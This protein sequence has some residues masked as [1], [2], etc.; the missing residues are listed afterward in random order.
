MTPATIK[1][2]KKRVAGKPSKP[3]PDFPL[4]PHASGR[5]AK[6]IRQQFCYFGKVA[7]DPRGVAALAIWL[8][9]KDELLAG[10]KP[11]GAREGLTIKGLVNEFLNAKRHLL[12]TRE[13]SARMFADWYAACEA[14]TAEYGT[15]RFVDD[16]LPADFDGLRR[17]LE[18]RYGPHRL[19]STV[20]RVRG[21]FKF[22][23]E[24]R[25]IDRPTHFGTGF[26][27]PSKKTMR[28]HRAKSG[29]KMFEA[30]ELRKIIDGAGVPL[31]AMILLGA[32]CGFGNSDIANL[33]LS[34]VDLAAGWVNFPRPKTGIN[35]R[36]PLWKETIAA[37]QAAIDER[38]TP[39][40]ADAAGLLFVTCRGAKWGGSSIV[41]TEV[42]SDGDESS[43]PAGAKEKKPK[44]KADD[45]IAKEFRKLLRTLDLHRVGVGFYGLR[46][47][48]ETV[49]G[50]SR[51]QIA[52]DA[53]MGHSRDDMA[54]VY[55]ERIEDS[56][57]VAVVDHVR[58]WL[59]KADAKGKKATKKSAK[60]VG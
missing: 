9:D 14:I 22:A 49:A 33:P 17:K 37:I 18:K 55:R 20:G 45:P 6:K 44:L 2:S 53:I 34:A 36:C 51:D 27:K 10:R 54:G 25:L 57:L 47:G 23:L 35:R 3:R 31:R 59:P 15:A 7:D 21:V 13:L 1:L 12:D 58:K 19:G 42:E 29:L 26:A 48:F 5:W 41:E 43:E 16:L 11:R 40:K 60:M 8:R 30:A 50:G 39:K 28:L 32:N 38:P 46:H 56:R 4:F 52:V 24:N